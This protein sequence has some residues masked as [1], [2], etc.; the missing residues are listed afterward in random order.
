MI[1]SPA[2]DP[3]SSLAFSGAGVASASVTALCP[4]PRQSGATTLVLQRHRSDFDR[5]SV[6]S[7]GVPSAH[8]AVP[9]RPEAGQAGRI[10]T[11]GS[12][13]SRLA[14]SHR[15]DRAAENCLG[16]CGLVA[17][18]VDSRR[19]GRSLLPVPIGTVTSGVWM[20]LMNIM[21]QHDAA[22]AGI[23][24]GDASQS[25]AYSI[26]P[27]SRSACGSGDNGHRQPSVTGRHTQRCRACRRLELAVK[28]G[29]GR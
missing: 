28:R 3:L 25:R 16:V 23:G 7:A 27:F 22:D 4:K 10:G 13:S 11:S 6:T 29:A 19:A 2:R 20:A 26:R 5:R 18:D 12:T 24:D 8:E 21:P 9:C 17:H 15:P 1:G 14:A